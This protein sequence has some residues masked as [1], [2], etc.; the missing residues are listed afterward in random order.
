[1][2]FLY[3][4]I[5]PLPHFSVLQLDGERWN[6]P[7]GS[8]PSCSDYAYKAGRK[9]GE[10]N[11]GQA[12]LQAVKQLCVW[13]KTTSSWNVN[14]P[15]GSH[16]ALSPRC[17]TGGHDGLEGRGRQL[18]Q[19]GRETDS[20]MTSQKCW[21]LYLRGASKGG[22]VLRGRRFCC[23]YLIQCTNRNTLTDDSNFIHIRIK[24]FI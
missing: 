19:D 1:M 3:N 22:K 23:E 10:V 7:F 8:S 15:A 13:L 9:L 18:G 6:C 14:I 21:K 24:R 12:V 20:F 2:C 4:I 11:R 5:Q 16:H 17:F